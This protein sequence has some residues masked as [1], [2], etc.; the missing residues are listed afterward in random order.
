MILYFITYCLYT[1]E[2]RSFPMRDRNGM[3][4]DG[5]E[6]KKDLGGAEGGQTVIRTHCIR[7]DSIYNTEGKDLHTASSKD[8]VST[9]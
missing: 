1:L 5:G 6:G 2:A 4:S 8:S 7:Q 9:Y 3:D